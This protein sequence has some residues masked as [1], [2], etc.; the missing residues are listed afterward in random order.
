MESQKTCKLFGAIRAVLGIKDVLPL[1]H[2]PLGCAY[3]IKYLLSVRS[4]K[5]I[6]ILTTNMDQ[7]D[8]VF[9][10]E[11]KLE[12]K[13]IEV[14]KKYSPKLIVVLT[15]CASS[16]IGEDTGRVIKNVKDNINAEI[17][18]INAGGFEGTQVDGYEE[19]LFK[20]IEFMDYRKSKNKSSINLVGQ[21]RGGKDLR[22][23][24]E[25]LKGLKIDVNCVL[26]SGSTLNDLKEAGNASLNVSMCEASGRAPCETMQE[27]FNIPYI[28]E[29]APIGIQ[30]TSKFFNKICSELNIEYTLKDEEKEVK[31]K[32]KEYSKD[33]E[34]KK[35]AIIAGPTRAIALTN[36][37]TEIGILPVLICLDFEGEFTMENLEKVIENSKI[38][39]IV[40]REPEYFEILECIKKLK[41]DII[42]GG[43]G[44]TGLSEETNIP[45]LDVMH[46]NK[47]TMG[48][49]GVLDMIKS[50]RK[51]L[52]K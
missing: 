30:A 9:G 33:L 46:A 24:K 3:H 45:L 35:A 50:I 31:N 5:P 26:T 28:Q 10:A 22:N 39:P 52:V 36:F 32:I 15:S 34:G 25:D 27:K 7:N 44:E 8:V 12:E 51:V 18:D 21:F 40:L 14:D 48:F 43:L 2:G 13:I 29:I 4:G 1:I 47:V 38:N 49:K 23:L 6:R 16:I 20:L 17:I 11:D 19:C 42:L 37:I 41:P